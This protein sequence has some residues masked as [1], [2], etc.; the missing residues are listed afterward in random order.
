MI[1]IK[2]SL[3]KDPSYGIFSIAK[4]L[5]ITDMEAHDKQE[6]TALIDYMIHH[7]EHHNEELEELASSLKDMNEDAHSKV[8]EAINEFKKGNLALEEALKELGK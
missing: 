1:L 5:S 6:L 4:Y 7:N 8:K 2:I 3:K